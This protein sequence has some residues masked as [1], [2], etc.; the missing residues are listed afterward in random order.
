MGTQPRGIA[1]VIR[2]P[3]AQSEA[4]APRFANEPAG[5]GEWLSSHREETVRQLATWQ[6]P[7]LPNEVCTRRLVAP[8]WSRSALRCRHRDSDY[9]P[10]KSFGAK[11]RNAEGPCRAG[12]SGQRPRRALMHG[13]ILIA[14]ALFPGF[15]LVGS[16]HAVG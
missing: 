14:L 10:C 15:F 12:D 11:A 2:I 16:F 9:G 4:P 7:A 8:W 5:L 3:N 1:Q 6:A 13:I